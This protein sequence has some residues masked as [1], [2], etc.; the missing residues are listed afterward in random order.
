MIGYKKQF[1]QHKL[2]IGVEE[3]LFGHIYENKKYIVIFFLK[4]VK[5]IELLLNII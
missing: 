5:K 1:H 3:R 4:C 2:N